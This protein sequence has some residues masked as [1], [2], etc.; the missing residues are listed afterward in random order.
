M[1]GKPIVTVDYFFGVL[2]AAK[3]GNAL[4]DP[5]HY[6]PSPFDGS[7]LAPEA[8]TLLKMNLR[9]QTLFLGKEFYFISSEQLANYTK[10][11]EAAGKKSMP[12]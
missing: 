2:D 8:T 7:V 10:I 1:A 12:M 6:L 4:P 9:R 3:H 11:I 5:E